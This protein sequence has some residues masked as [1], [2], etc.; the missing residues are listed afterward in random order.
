MRTKLFAAVDTALGEVVAMLVREY[1]VDAVDA[2]RRIAGA[3]DA[4]APPG[5]DTTAWRNDPL[6][7][8]ATTAMR[9]A[10]DPLAD[11]WTYLPN[12]MGDA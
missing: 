12:P 3:V 8:K 2:W 11:Q 9:L 1:G 7:V 5:P 10:A 6:L 4:A